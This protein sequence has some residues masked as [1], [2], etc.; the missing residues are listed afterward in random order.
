MYVLVT[1][2]DY[3]YSIFR[4]TFQKFNIKI[5]E[6]VNLF[7]NEIFNMEKM[8]WHYIDIRFEGVIC[9]FLSFSLLNNE[10]YSY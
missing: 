1:Q 8:S 7:N 4:S 9:I 3:L 6:L 2:F 5:N 10:D